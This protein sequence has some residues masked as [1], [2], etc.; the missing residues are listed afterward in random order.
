MA[1]IKAR[2]DNLIFTG[3]VVDILD[4]KTVGNN[5]FQKRTFAIDRGGNHP[6]RYARRAF[7]LIKENCAIGDLMKVGETVT[8]EAEFYSNRFD[9]N[10][11][12][13]YFHNL[14]ASRV[15]S[16]NGV[17]FKPQIEAG[18][19]HDWA[20][21]RAFGL[22]QG[23]TEAQLVERGKA[24]GAK[25]GKKSADYVLADWTALTA[26]V[27]AAHGGAADDA[28]ADAVNEELPF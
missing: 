12:P 15:F 5:G 22:A 26:E 18:G 2:G 10:G 21:F 1:E 19:V 27:V 20:T 25:T 23:E 8:V 14:T 6:D 9:G 3:K 7:E 24:Y 11:E 4:T 17:E 16:E 28:A 13:R